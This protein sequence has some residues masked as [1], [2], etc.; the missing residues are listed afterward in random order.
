[1]SECDFT[2]TVPKNHGIPEGTTLQSIL[3]DGMEEYCDG[4]GY[5]TS[6]RA[7]DYFYYG[8]PEELLSAA[9]YRVR[10]Y[11]NIQIAIR[12]QKEKETACSSTS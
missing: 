3:G 8:V 7:W 4:W 5:D 2:L 12:N 9:A 6:S 1:M 11:P 10:N